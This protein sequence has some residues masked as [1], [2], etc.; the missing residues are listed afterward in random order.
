MIL[1]L[2]LT[3]TSFLNIKSEVVELP[4]TILNYV[5]Q[6]NMLKV[7]RIIIKIYEFI[8]FFLRCLNWWDW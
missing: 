6:N 3:A 7:I 8:L 5:V 2:Q 4:L 1:N